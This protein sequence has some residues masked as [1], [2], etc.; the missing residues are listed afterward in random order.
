MP[1]LSVAVFFYCLVSSQRASP[2]EIDAAFGLMIDR[3]LLNRFG[4]ECVCSSL[5]ASNP[6]Q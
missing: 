3:A 4:F 5:R 1:S 6:M 2:G